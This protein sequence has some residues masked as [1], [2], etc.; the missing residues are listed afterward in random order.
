MIDN[1]NKH[2][3]I[4]IDILSYGDIHYMIDHFIYVV[5]I[6]KPR[7][8]MVFIMWTLVTKISVLVCNTLF[9]RAQNIYKH[10]CFSFTALLILNSQNH[11]C[12]VLELLI[13][14]VGWLL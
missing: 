14:T 6:I 10:A 12:C 3:L 5:D 1:E 8:F 9:T 2:S 4:M 11:F 13:F 7:V